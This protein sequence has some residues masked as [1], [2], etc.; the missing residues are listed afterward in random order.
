MTEEKSFPLAAESVVKAVS[1]LTNKAVAIIWS[2]KPLLDCMF[3]SPAYCCCFPTLDLAISSRTAF[4]RATLT[5]HEQRCP[6]ERAM[7]A[8]IKQQYLLGDQTELYCTWCHPKKHQKTDE[9]EFSNCKMLIRNWPS[10]CHYALNKLYTG[11]LGLDLFFTYF[12]IFLPGTFF[13]PC[14]LIS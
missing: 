6:L 9:Q 1:L 12:K 8:R 5:D 11:T 7:K 14:S 2:L 4:G 10:L 13:C 3:I